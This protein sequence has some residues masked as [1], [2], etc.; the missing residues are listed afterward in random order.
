[1]RILQETMVTLHEAAQTFPSNRAGKKMNFST[2][3]RW[4]LK[5]V[6]AIDGRVVKLE[7]ARVGGRWLTSKEA[8]QRFSAALAPTNDDAEPIRTPTTRRRESD[9]TKKKLKELGV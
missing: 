6:R 5:G 7:L 2:V 9:A 4:G 3:W 1:M 8:L